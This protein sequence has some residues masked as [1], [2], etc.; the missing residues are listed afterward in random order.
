MVSFHMSLVRWVS[1]TGRIIPDTALSA[2]LRGCFEDPQAARRSKFWQTRPVRDTEPSGDASAENHAFSA[3]SSLMWASP[4]QAGRSEC[5]EI[6]PVKLTSCYFD[7]VLEIKGDP[8]TLSVRT[9]VGLLVSWS[10]LCPAGISGRPGHTLTRFPFSFAVWH[11]GFRLSFEHHQHCSSLSPPLSLSV[12]PG[13]AKHSI[14][15]PSI[16]CSILAELPRHVLCSKYVMNQLY[17]ALFSSKETL[18][19]CSTIFLLLSLS[20]FLLQNLLPGS[21]SANSID[22]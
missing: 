18:K 1:E 10:I 22:F 9:P 4:K 5:K 2:C 19:N 20:S 21:P 12:T 17:R 8:A 3:A 11:P 7:C 6:I 14:Y 16:S 15:M 13:S